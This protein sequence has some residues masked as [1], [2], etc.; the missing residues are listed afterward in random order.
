MKTISLVLLSMLIEIGCSKHSLTVQEKIDNNFT[1][2]FEHSIIS[3][4]DN[5]LDFNRRK[6][7]IDL[8][9]V[10]LHEGIEPVKFQARAGWS[11]EKLKEKTLI[12]FFPD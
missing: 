8:F 4:G 5:L 2:K 1:S 9:L 12:L 3:K 10:A 7:S 6:D 11:D